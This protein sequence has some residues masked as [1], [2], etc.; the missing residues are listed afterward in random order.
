MA[1]RG[2]ATLMLCGCL[3]LALLCRPLLFVVG[4]GNG[5]HHAAAAALRG[6]AAEKAIAY[7]TY[8]DALPRGEASGSNGLVQSCLVFLAAA[9]LGL[10][11]GFTAPQEC[12]AKGQALQNL[13][14]KRDPKAMTWEDRLRVEMAS[15]DQ[16]REEAIVTENKIKMA[17]ASDPKEKRV[18]DAMKLMQFLAPQELHPSKELPAYNQSFM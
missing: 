15:A 13:G 18:D 3:L 7:D 17:E 8:G 4:T 16:A 12:Y 5:S 9:A 1:F 2:N 10:C 11:V 14:A 6:A